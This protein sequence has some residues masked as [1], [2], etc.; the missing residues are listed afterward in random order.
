MKKEGAVSQ[1]NHVG[2]REVLAPE[3]G[4]RVAPPTLANVLN[5]RCGRARARSTPVASFTIAGLTQDAVTG[6]VA[7]GQEYSQK[8]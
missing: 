2:K 1:A 5:R 3:G 4:G 6:I 7:M 8:S